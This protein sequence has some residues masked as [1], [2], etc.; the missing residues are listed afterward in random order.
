LTKAKEIEK[1]GRKIIHYEIGDPDFDTPQNVIDIAKNALDNNFTHYTS[2]GGLP[3]FR[4]AIRQYID[5]YYGFRPLF[6][7]VVACPA[8]ALIDFICK[9]VANPGD[10]IIYPNPGFPTYYSSI[11]YNGFVPVPVYLTERNDFR[12]NPKDIEK[13]IT[14][15]TKLIIINSPHNP[16]GA[17]MTGQEIDAIYKLAEKHDIFILSDEVYSRII[18]D[19]GFISPSSH[20]LCKERVIVLKSLSKIFSMSGWRLGYAVAPLHLAEKL[21]LMI[22]TVLSCL[23]PFTQMAGIEALNGKQTEMNRRIH[24]LKLRRDT[25]IR[26][27]NSIDGIHCNSAHGAFYAFVNIKDTGMTCDKYASGLLDKTGV[28]VLPGN[29]FGDGGEGYIRMSY[30]SSGFEDIAESLEKMK[31]FHKDL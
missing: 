5:V 19:R 14:D 17:V 23:P 9:C 18:Y 20:D 3:E 12:M 6:E 30:A 11:V 29:C 21:S 22:Q 31:S 24:N 13:A 1:T 8:N 27:I 7:Q 15:K 26:G 16:T 10:E 25:L 4:E 2:S 28:C